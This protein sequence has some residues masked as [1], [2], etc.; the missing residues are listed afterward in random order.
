MTREPTMKRARD[1][2]THLDRRRAVRWSTA[3]AVLVAVGLVA[4]ACSDNGVAAST[5]TSTTTTVADR[6]EETPEV[7]IKPDIARGI[8]E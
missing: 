3:L 1:E 2:E 8:E 4:A 6:P 7:E 5:G